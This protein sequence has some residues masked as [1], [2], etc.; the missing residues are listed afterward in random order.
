MK[1]RSVGILITVASLAAAAAQVQRPS[2]AFPELTGPYLGQVLPGLRA[3]LFAPGIVSTG[4]TEREVAI[5]R[6]GNEIFFE[7]A[8][9]K[10]ATIMTTR[11]LNG[12]WT[13]P[14]VAPFAA[15]LR[16]FHFE[17]CLSA[18]D[19]TILFLSTRPRAG[20]EVKPGWGHQNIW[21]ANRS[22]D[23]RWGEP[24]DL[25]EPINTA[26]SEFYP[27]LT[28]DGTLYFTRANAAGEGARIMRA[29]RSGNRY[30]APEVLP[31]AVNGKGSPYNA[32][33]APD[34]S[35][36]IVCVDGRDDSVTPK[37]PNYYAFFR[38]ADDRWSEGV[39][40]GPEI[41]FPGASAGA[42]YV[43]RDGRYFFFGSTLS[44]DPE[45][46]AAAPLTSRRLMDYFMA[47][48]NGNSDVYWIEAAF[49]QNLR[50]RD[51]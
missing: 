16:F 27:S 49:I 41:N 2:T 38:S 26:E 13:E 8:A 15:D 37:R 44:R 29:R 9:G 18:D 14:V 45:S 39:N 6:N 30:Q 34:E 24:Y 48:R 3:A 42:P 43:T 21:A 28:N 4:M 40:L 17:P 7:Q 47:P 36:L 46:S 31:A 35:F 5:T 23:G 51:R 33:I 19:Q 20:E 1:H 50:P 12:R 25:G 32:C 10:V 11:L 22:T